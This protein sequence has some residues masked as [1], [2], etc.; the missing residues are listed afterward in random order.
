M[1]CD[2]ATAPSSSSMA[3]ASICSVPLPAM[4]FLISSRCRPRVR[5]AIASIV[6]LLVIAPLITPAPFNRP[7]LSTSTVAAVTR[8]VR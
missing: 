5:S 7:P 2:D 6:P 3:P 8:P 4:S 1:T